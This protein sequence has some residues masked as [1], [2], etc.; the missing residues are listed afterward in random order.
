MTFNNC[1]S[2]NYFIRTLYESLCIIS[3]SANFKNKNY[4]GQP[5]KTIYFRSGPHKTFFQFKPA[6]TL[7][8]FFLLE[9][10]QFHVKYNFSTICF[11]LIVFY[12]H[13]SQVTRFC[14]LAVNM[15]L[16]RSSRPE[17]FL[18]S[19]SENMQQIYRRTPMPKCAFIKVAL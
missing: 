5:Q 14:L 3:T 9:Q 4:L 18:R 16:F 19:C 7:T 17:V 13:L 2:Y 10:L 6:G 11:P 8:V 1:R 15:Q 12:F